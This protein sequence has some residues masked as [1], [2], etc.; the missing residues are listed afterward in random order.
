MFPSKYYSSH[1]FPEF[2]GKAE[3]LQIFRNWFNIANVKSLSSKA[4]TNDEYG[5]AII[6]EGRELINFFYKF[7]DWLRKWMA[8]KKTGLST[9]T[10]VASIQTTEAFIDLS[11]YLRDGN[12]L[13][14]ILLG[15]IQS[16]Y[17]A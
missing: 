16:D 8:S 10:F 11:N 7:I 1:D 17:L 15:N 4:R 6:K 3:V 9:Q 2:S 13:E 5:A 14:F 12:N